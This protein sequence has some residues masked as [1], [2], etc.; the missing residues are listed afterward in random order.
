M[1]KIKEE[2]ASEAEEEER[3]IFYVA[4]TRAERHLIVSGATDTT[5]WPEPKPLGTPMD[6]VLPAFAPGARLLWERA[7]PVRTRAAC[8]A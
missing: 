4:M 3:R 6:W 2:R 7:A 5:K 8:A 1:D